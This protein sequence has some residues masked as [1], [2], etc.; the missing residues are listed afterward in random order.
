MKPGEVA[1]LCDDR[2]QYFNDG[3]WTNPVDKWQDPV[4]VP[5][6]KRLIDQAVIRTEDRHHRQ[7]R[8][9]AADKIPLDIAIFI[10]D[11]ILDAD[12]DQDSVKDAQNMLTAF[13]WRLPDSYWQSQF[14]KYLVFEFNDLVKQRILTGS[15]SPWALPSYLLARNGITGVG[16]GIEREL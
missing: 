6:L 1:F 2:C 5:E 4:N 7:L 8:N 3:D 10:V 9:A 13:Q 15:T 12:H 14:P 11:N 16:S